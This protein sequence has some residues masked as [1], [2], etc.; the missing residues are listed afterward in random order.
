[1]P[2]LP[3]PAMRNSFA[4]SHAYTDAQLRPRFFVVALLFLLLLAM[5]ATQ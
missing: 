5:I 3:Q 1:M 4:N 2:W